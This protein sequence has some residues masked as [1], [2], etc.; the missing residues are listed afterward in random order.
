MP[1]QLQIC[2]QVYGT[3]ALLVGFFFSKKNNPVIDHS[4]NTVNLTSLKSPEFFRCK[5][6]Q[7]SNYKN[8]H[9]TTTFRCIG[10]MLT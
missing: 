10:K 3:L 9:A 8:K 5:H 6:M 2:M 1:L 7:S 4:V